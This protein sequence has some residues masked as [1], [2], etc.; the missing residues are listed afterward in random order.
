MGLIFMFNKK[1]VS[2]FLVAPT[3]VAALSLSAVSSSV[4]A[5]EETVNTKSKTEKN[6][7][8]NKTNSL[9]PATISES[10]IKEI[11]YISFLIARAKNIEIIQGNLNR[12]I[13]RKIE[14]NKLKFEPKPEVAKYYFNERI[15]GKSEYTLPSVNMPNSVYVDVNNGNTTGMNPEDLEFKLTRDDDCVLGIK[16][17]Q[18]VNKK[19]EEVVLDLPKSFLVNSPMC[20]YILAEM[21]KL[22]SDMNKEIAYDTDNNNIYTEDIKDEFKDLDRD[23]KYDEKEVT[24]KVELHDNLFSSGGWCNKLSVTD[25]LGHTCVNTLL[26]NSGEPSEY[27]IT[28]TSYQLNE[29]KKGRGKVRWEQIGEGD[30]GGHYYGYI[31]KFN[32]GS[33]IRLR[34]REKGGISTGGLRAYFMWFLDSTK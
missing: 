19:T 6:T 18:L 16:K 7:N 29:L 26:D 21:Y 12:Y 31:L 14:G 13:A 34:V 10:E 23:T 20:L 17:V 11:S 32:D 28:L 15:Y 1:I 27:G 25:K 22:D 8:G 24:Y 9:E 30:Q 5:L 4:S 33:A 3:S 2:K